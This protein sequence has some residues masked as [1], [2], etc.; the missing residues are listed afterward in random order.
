MSNAGDN[1]IK[2]IKNV[3]KANVNSN[4][5]YKLTTENKF[6]RENSELK[7]KLMEIEVNEE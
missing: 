2:E 5:I 4:T 3:I 7:M 6:I 1:C